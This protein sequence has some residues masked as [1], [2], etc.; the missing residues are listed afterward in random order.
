[1]GSGPVQ[2]DRDQFNGIGTSLMG[3]GPIS[4]PANKKKVGSLLTH[5]LITSDKKNDY[6]QKFRTIVVQN[7]SLYRQPAE[8]LIHILIMF[9][10]LHLNLDYEL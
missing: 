5:R 6:W 2:W 4:K 9:A 8:V 10:L 1:M 7:A 3:L